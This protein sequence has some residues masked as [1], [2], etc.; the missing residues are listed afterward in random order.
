LRRR[1]EARW[2]R[3]AS[4]LPDL[5]ALQRRLLLNAMQLVRPGGVVGYIT[6]SP[7]LEET[8]EVVDAVRRSLPADGF[9][10]IDAR[11][12]LPA[13]LPGLGPGPDLQLWPHRH[14]TDA[15]YQALLRRRI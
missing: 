3:R 9:E 7:L 6:C 4:D 14:G 10:Q 2:R 13:V 15:M 8:V 11:S 5:V 12:C 1:P